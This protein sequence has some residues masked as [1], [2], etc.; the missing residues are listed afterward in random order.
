[1]LTRA[2]LHPRLRDHRLMVWIYL[3]LYLLGKRLTERAELATLRELIVP[4]MVIAD[5]GANAGFYTIEMASMVGP[6]GRIVAF[7]PDPLNFRFL[8]GRTRRAHAS[9]VE[10][11]QMAVGDKTGRA[12]L[13]CSAYNRADNRLHASHHEAHVEAS[14]VHV[15]SLDDFVQS[16]H[17]TAIDGI[18]ID[19][20][21]AEE[22]VLIGART[23]LERRVQW[24]WV[25]FSPAHLRAAGTDPGRFV[26]M[27]EQL[28]MDIFELDHAGSLSPFSGFESYSRRIGAGYGDLVLRARGSLDLPRR[29]HR[30]TAPVIP[31]SR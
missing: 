7:E 31:E 29:A 27:L 30:N 9:N 19:V 2:L 15:C 8:Q 12:I 22:Q 13:Y 18:K 25:E 26:A 11:F 14:E 21:G 16:H 20:Q 17:N 6:S 4:G 24:I 10:A 3:R 23:V 1:V 28:G 5:I